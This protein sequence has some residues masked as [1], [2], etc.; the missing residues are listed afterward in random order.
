MALP[1]GIP[2]QMAE[3]F[4]QIENQEIPPA[5][6]CPSMFV[7]CAIK[8]SISVMLLYVLLLLAK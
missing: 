1:N 7:F 5:R 3:A 2:P 8:T 4:Q 6:F